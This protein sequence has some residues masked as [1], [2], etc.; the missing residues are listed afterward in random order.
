MGLV[1]NNPLTQL[2][3]LLA[4]DTVVMG[5]GTDQLWLN[6]VGVLHSKRPIPE[7]PSI[8]RKTN[9]FLVQALLFQTGML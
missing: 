7:T 8:V 4:A 5:L 1:C 6:S 3:K 2:Y 9:V